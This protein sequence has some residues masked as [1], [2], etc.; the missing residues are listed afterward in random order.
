MTGLVSGFLNELARLMT[1]CPLEP[2][3]LDALS[4]RAAREGTLDG[5]FA[6]MFAAR[7]F[8]RGVMRLAAPELVAA[9]YR[10]ILGRTPDAGGLA[11]Y[12]AEIGQTGDLAPLVGKLIRSAEFCA[13]AD[14][15]TAPTV[16]TG[17]LQAVCGD[18]P[19]APPAAP[20]RAE[21][22]LRSIL[23]LP[24][25]A[26][27]KRALIDGCPD[28][29]HLQCRETLV[30]Q[31]ARHSAPTPRN[32]PEDLGAVK[33]IFLHLP[34][35]GGTT[36]RTALEKCFEPSLRC[37]ERH[38]GLHRHPAG[39]L[40]RWRFFSGH[41]SLH[42]CGF[43][44]GPKHVVTMLR[45][46]VDRLVSLYN[47]LRAHTNEFIH[48]MGTRLP[49]LARQH[50]IRDFFSAKEVRRHPSINNAMVRALASTFPVDRWEA[51]ARLPD[52]DRPADLLAPALENLRSL[53][54]FGIL[55][56]AGESAGL[57]FRALGLPPPAALERRMVLTEM[58]GR[59][60]TVEKIELQDCDDA[61]RDAMSPLIEA[62]LALYDRALAIFK[63][64]GAAAG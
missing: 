34:K 26:E 64:R 2:G 28:P 44:P 39:E 22:L 23:A 43:I 13:N 16:L 59:V 27:L 63:E 14:Q 11:T 37:P 25:F 42:S 33:T 31:A 35:T 12:S 52:D 20:E 30:R 7:D 41:F 54:A 21:A 5:A 57:I 32:A 53:R 4:R 17:I 29:E 56:H 47:F 10:G 58:F 6:E 36:L 61:T 45:H 18:Q 50:D 49:V 19:P 40:A 15:A 62:D 24:Q 48:Q 46:P 8:R 9:A 38:D 51:A 3:T 1:G 55:E 60:P